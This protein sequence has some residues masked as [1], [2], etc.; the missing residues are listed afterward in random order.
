MSR[1]VPIEHNWPFQPLHPLTVTFHDAGHILGAASIHIA[2]ETREI[3]FSGDIGPRGRPVMGDPKPPPH[4]HYVVTEATYGDRLHPSADEARSH[5]ASSLLKVAQRGGVAIIPVFAVGRAQTLLYELGE[6]MRTGQ[7]PTMPVFLDSPLAIEAVSVFRRHTEYFD[8]STNSLLARG[9][10]PLFFPN[11]NFCRTVEESKALNDLEGPAVIFAGSG[12]CTGGRV[13]HHLRH[14][15]PNH[16]DAVI[17]VGYQA[18][19]TLGRILSDGT[20]KVKLYGEWVSVKAEIIN[21]AG[22]SAH[23][24]QKGLLQWLAA[25]QGVEKVF[26]N[27]SEKDVAPLYAQ[28]VTNQTGLQPVLPTLF[29]TYQF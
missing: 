2:T 14:R 29:S 19:G 21:I 26:I 9:V 24:D 7:I 23:A 22:F 27:H 1:F 17:F 3:V 10:D 5:L 28:A 13:R 12:M 8:P 11:L 20:E 15:L 16:K 4:A 18:E 6:L 25:I